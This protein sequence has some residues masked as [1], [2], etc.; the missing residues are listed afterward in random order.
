MRRLEGMGSAATR[1]CSAKSALEVTAAPTPPPA[2]SERAA[3]KGDQDCVVHTE[4]THKTDHRQIRFALSTAAR[5]AILSMTLALAPLPATAPATAHR[6]AN[7]AACRRASALLASCIAETHTCGSG[8]VWCIRQ[9]VV[10][11]L[12]HVFEQASAPYPLKVFKADRT[13]SNFGLVGSGASPTPN[14]PNRS[15]AALANPEHG[16]VPPEVR[17]RAILVVPQPQHGELQSMRCC[18]TTEG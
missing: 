15:R 18:P 9:E 1:M 8:W 11:A 3:A 4:I 2:S 16:C 7:S 12:S 14:V 5:E 10:H 6:T 13:S 17:I